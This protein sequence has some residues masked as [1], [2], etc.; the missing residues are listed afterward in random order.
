M[1]ISEHIYVKFLILILGLL[2]C[3]WNIKS[4][5][6][7]MGC[8]IFQWAI[9]QMFGSRLGPS[10]SLRA[11]STN[12]V[13]FG[14]TQPLKHRPI[15]QFMDLIRCVKI[16]LDLNHGSAWFDPQINYYF[17]LNVKITLRLIYR[18]CNPPILQ[19]FQRKIID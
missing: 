17:I 8:M 19:L 16:R 14:P 4:S 1:Y 6:F 9:M 10:L 13:L 18:V 15:A 12:W 3:E 7:E 5:L 11:S 2:N